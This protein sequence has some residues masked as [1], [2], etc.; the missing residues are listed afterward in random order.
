MSDKKHEEYE[1]LWNACSELL[2][3]DAKDILDQVT[4]TLFIKFA[5][6]RYAADRDAAFTTPPGGRFADMVASKGRADI[7]VRLNNVIATL[8]E[9]NPGLRQMIGTVNFDDG[10]KLGSGAEMTDRLTRLISFF[11]RVEF[12]DE[13]G[14]MVVA[15]A[16]P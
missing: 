12:R 5:S 11:E 6:D 14:E 1:S 15:D 7:G 10:Q 13:H 8:V 9:A 16:E 4:A 2:G 3:G